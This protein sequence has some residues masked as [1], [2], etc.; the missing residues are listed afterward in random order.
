MTLLLD[1]PE[2]R[3]PRRYQ[4]AQTGPI[5]GRLS[6]LPPL[7]RRRQAV[8]PLFIAI[9]I[10]HPRKE[11]NSDA[12]AAPARSCKS[13]SNGG[14]GTRLDAAQL[15]K[16]AAGGRQLSDVARKRQTVSLW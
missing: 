14:R 11:S 12:A 7:R 9:N 13:T 1:V 6:E 4:T 15:Q 3:N 8:G 2:N 10:G 5:G 16:S